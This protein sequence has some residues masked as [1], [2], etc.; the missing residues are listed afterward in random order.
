MNPPL[1]EFVPVRSWHVFGTIRSN[2]GVIRFR[3]FDRRFFTLF[4]GDWFSTA[5]ELAPAV[6]D[7]IFAYC[8]GRASD[9]GGGRTCLVINV[10]PDSA[11]EVK[12]HLIRIL[13]DPASWNLLEDAA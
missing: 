5:W 8:E 2:R 4:D 9:W 7:A 11:D 13:T 12:H 10:L 3:V 6:R 1:I